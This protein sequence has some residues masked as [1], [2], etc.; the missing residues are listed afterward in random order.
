MVLD[1]RSNGGGALSSLALVAEFVL[2]ATPSTQLAT[3]HYR[4]RPARQWW[5]TGILGDTTLATDA[6][7]AVLIGP[8]TYSSGEALAYHLHHRG[9]VRTFGCRTPGAA[10]H[11]TPVRVTPS[12]TAL[13][14]EATPVDPVTGGNWEGVGVSP[15]VACDPADA[16]SMAREW[17]RSTRGTPDA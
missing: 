15:T 10:D 14:P 8:G 3:V 1:L 6:R 16:A 12:V 11:V 4:D 7:V 17:L 5:T 2:G 13:M 9:R